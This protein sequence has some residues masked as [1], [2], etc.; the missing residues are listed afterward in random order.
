[1]KINS[2]DIV[3]RGFVSVVALFSTLHALCRGESNIKKSEQEQ[4]HARIKT[5]I[6]RVLQQSNPAEADIL[7]ARQISCH[8]IAGG[9]YLGS[10]DAFVESTH[11]S[12]RNDR[13]CRRKY[14]TYNNQHGFH[15]VI[16]V[17][18]RMELVGDCLD[19]LP[20]SSEDLERSFQKH[21]MQWLDAGRKIFDHPASWIP[22]VHNC[23]LPHSEEA[24]KE[25]F[26]EG[27]SL[28]DYEAL[29][30]LKARNIER[31]PIEQW[32][33]PVFKHID[34]A[35]FGN[36]KT[37]VHCHG[38]I[39]RS[40]SVLAAYFIS[41]FDLTTEDA[42]AFLKRQRP[43]ISSKFEAELQEYERGVKDRARAICHL[44]A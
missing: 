11:L 19:L 10:S 3:K 42:L 43:C 13:N 29:N 30:A 22:L 8:P 4:L 7:T 41:R 28:E 5:Q 33:A 44:F 38:G 31:V 35:V 39:S 9:L 34:D 20:I 14:E 27:E 12:L 21:N 17:C 37:L 1:M 25:L 36:K 23:T 2:I 26:Q 15:T 6:H 24:L 40:A 16:T 18:Q 32:F